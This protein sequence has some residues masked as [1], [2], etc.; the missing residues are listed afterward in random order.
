MKEKS[1]TTVI[2]SKHYQTS[3]EY[4]WRS[5]YAAVYCCCFKYS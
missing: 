1:K 5:L 2:Y 3:R 4:K